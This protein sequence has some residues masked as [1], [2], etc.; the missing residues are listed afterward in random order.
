MRDYF[1]TTLEVNLR[2]DKRELRGIL[3][4]LQDQIG[5]SLK[6]LGDENLFGLN[7]LGIFQAN[8][9]RADMLAAR[10]KLENKIL[11]EFENMNKGVDDE[12]E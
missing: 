4:F 10:I 7:E 3:E 11:K 6:A 5:Q 12:A 9:P 2:A 1:K 8:G